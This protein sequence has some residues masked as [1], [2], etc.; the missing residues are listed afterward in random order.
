MKVDEENFQFLLEDVTPGFA[1]ALRR[2]VLSEV[3]SMAIDEV[4]IVENSSS[5]Y[6]EYIAHRLGLI[7]LKTNLKRYKVPERKEDLT[8]ENTVRLTLEVTC[9]REEQ[10]VYSGDLKPVDPFVEPVNMKIP[11]VKLKKGQKLVLEAIA[12]LGRGKEHAKWQ[13]V[14][15]VSYSYLPIVD[16]N[17][18]KCT[19]C[20]KCVDECPVGILEVMDGKA[21]VK[22]IYECLICKSCE[23]NCTEG[24]IKVRY[25][26]KS[27]IFSLEST[28]ALSA[29]E[30]IE[31]AINILINKLNNF[32]NKLT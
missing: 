14:S 27:F 24:S 13:P 31:E 28:G 22:N 2:T 7:P 16:I 4:I 25:N 20:S 10:M 15:T 8:P 19:G 17:L 23:E 5:F 26:P 18:Q 12:R 32:K 29:E 6:D 1:N 3:P 21:R 9:K 11:I 30:I